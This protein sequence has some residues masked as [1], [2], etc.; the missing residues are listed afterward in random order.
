MLNFN[1]NKKNS[2]FLETQ[3]QTC[4]QTFPYSLLYKKINKKLSISPGFCRRSYIYIYIYIYIY[5][6]FFYVFF[7]VLKNLIAN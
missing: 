5:R 6:L 1:K 2:N 3:I 4:S 7:V